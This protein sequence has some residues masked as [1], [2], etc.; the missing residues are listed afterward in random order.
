MST[1]KIL[2]EEM[3]S[4]SELRKNPSQY[5]TNNPVAVMS[6]NQTAGYMVGAELFE[7]MMLI[8][9]QSQRDKT[10]I[11]QFRPSAARLK[12]ISEEST[13]FLQQASDEDLGHFSE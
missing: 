5:F 11:G 13:R 8:I 3:V 10:I 6:H 4:V 1:H 2:A 7:K 9:E 12:Q